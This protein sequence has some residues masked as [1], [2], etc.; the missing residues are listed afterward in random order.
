M[1]VAGH[2]CYHG[3]VNVTNQ[4]PE[5]RPACLTATAARGVFL[6]LLV[7]HLAPA[8]ALAE[9]SPP[10]PAADRARAKAHFDRAEV[11]KQ[12]AGVR[13]E[14]GDSSGARETYQEAAAAY[15]EAF[16]LFP[17]PAF[18]YNAA[19][20]LRLG[21]ERAAA[22]RSYEKYLE[23]DPG[24]A[25]ADVAR[26]FLARLRGEPAGG[27]GRAGDGLDA[28]GQDRPAG[29]PEA[30][31]EAGTE[32]GAAPDAQSAAGAEPLAE[33]AELDALADQDEGT[34][35][36][37]T[38]RIA[39]IALAAA[40]AV[41]LGASIKFGNDARAI[42][43]ELSE[44]RFV[45]EVEDRERFA[46]G[47]RAERNMYILVGLG[48]AALVTGGVLYLM[49]RNDGQTERADARLAVAASATHE[50]ASML[51]WGRF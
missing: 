40:G 20:M 33:I 28:A 22:I 45:W 14:A 39:G 1:Q 4:L 43:D 3:R 27:A 10:A 36:G 50:G 18:V 44:D 2:G 51:L 25:K 26:A 12:R 49:G 42:A 47:E 8:H 46:E 5:R 11:L 17:H 15:L 19:Q 29:R 37:R 9:T 21:G 13:A 35:T 23:L 41:A 38:Q 24:G 30:R 16:D 32:A 7:A 31:T 48:S 34:D 6:A